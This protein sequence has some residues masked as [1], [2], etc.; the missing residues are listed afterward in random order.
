[1]ARPG[2]HLAAG[3]SQGRMAGEHL[4]PRAEGGVRAIMGQSSKDQS[5]QHANRLA[6]AGAGAVQRGRIQEGG[7]RLGRRAGR[8]HG[9]TAG[10]GGQ[11]AVRFAKR[12]RWWWQACRDG[13]TESKQSFGIPGREVRDASVDRRRTAAVLQAKAGHRSRNRRCAGSGRVRER[14]LEWR[15]GRRQSTKPTASHWPQIAVVYAIG[16]WQRT[17]RRAD[18]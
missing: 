13:T 8:A 1:L 2:V 5:P 12:G 11:I 15:D 14:G 16:S 18:S 7:Q 6:R 17:A 10:A 9:G 4:A 3:E